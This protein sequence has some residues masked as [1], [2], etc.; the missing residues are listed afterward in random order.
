MRWTPP[1]LTTEK[2]ELPQL[3]KVSYEYRMRHLN[4]EMER[5]KNRVRLLEDLLEET[6]Q[7]LTLVQGTIKLEEKKRI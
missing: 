2:M 4:G 6:K 1:G 5:Y 7:S 3:T